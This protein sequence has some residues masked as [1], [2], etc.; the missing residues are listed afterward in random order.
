M[1]IVAAE[2]SKG[3]A[4]RAMRGWKEGVFSRGTKKT[5]LCLLQLRKHLFWMD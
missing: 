1:S 2:R 3:Q 5:V 4:I